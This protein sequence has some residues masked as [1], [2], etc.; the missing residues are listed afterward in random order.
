VGVG[1]RDINNPGGGEV[2]MKSAAALG[3]PSQPG[4]TSWTN[5]NLAGKTSTD[6]GRVRAVVSGK[7]FL[8]TKAVSGCRVLASASARPTEAI[9]SGQTMKTLA[10]SIYWIF[11][12]GCIAPVTA[13]RP[14][15][16]SG[17]A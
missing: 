7:A 13:G 17:Q 1:D 6:N 16:T 14:G 15:K 11:Q 3:A 9:S 2:F 5:T 10:W 12:Q 8:D 4:W